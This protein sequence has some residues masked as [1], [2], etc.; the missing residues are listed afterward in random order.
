MSLTPKQI[1]EQ[2]LDWLAEARTRIVADMQMPLQ[3]NEKTN[4]RD[5]V[6]NVDRE[7]EQYYVQQIH[8]LMPEAQ[9][10]SEE[11]Y[12]DHVS[13]MMGDVWYID[14]IDGT[15]NFVEQRAEFATMLALYHDG[16][17]VCAW[18]MDVMQND[19]I[20][21]GPALGVFKNNASLPVPMNKV[22]AD[23]LMVVSGARLIANQMGLPQ[24]SQQALGFRVYGSAGISFMHVLEGRAIGYMSKMKPWDFAPGAALAKS[25]GLMISD[26]DG[27]PLNMLLSNSVVVSTPNA[28]EQIMR[29]EKQTNGVEAGTDIRL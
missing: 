19:I 22:L 29:I 11:G 15:L 17:P 3:V 10:I 28:H 20:H 4:A 12:G 18:I 23:G 25:F 5:L 9:I 6:T 16:E 8:T 14:P 27:E 24:V 1:D 2:V 7:I 13:S 26:I 21:G